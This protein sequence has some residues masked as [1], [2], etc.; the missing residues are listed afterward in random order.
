M[1]TQK[2]RMTTEQRSKDPDFAAK[3]RVLFR[4]IK[5]TH[6]LNNVQ[7]SEPPVSIARMTQN[8][9]TAIKPAAPTPTT[10]SLI[11]GNARYWAQNT[12][13]ILRDHYEDSIKN[14]MQI[15][16]QL[17]GEITQNFE[18]ASAWAR[19]QFGR[20]LKQA[21]LDN[22]WAKLRRELA[23]ARTDQV[24]SLHTIHTPSTADSGSR[25]GSIGRNPAVAQIP[26]EIT[27]LS[28][29]RDQAPRRTYSQVV[30]TQTNG[31]R[32][33]PT[34]A[35]QF[36]GGQSPTTA[37]GR[38]MPISAQVCDL[39]KK[40]RLVTTATMTTQRGGDWSPDIP[41]A[42]PLVREERFAGTIRPATPPSAWYAWTSPSHPTSS[43]SKGPREREMGLLP[44]P[45]PED[46]GPVLTGGRQMTI[47]AQVHHPARGS[48]RTTE[49]TAPAQ[50][51][52]GGW[53][54]VIPIIQLP[55]RE[56]RTTRASRPGTPSLT[57]DLQRGNT[58]T[59]PTSPA[60]TPE[61]VGETESE[62]L[63][64]L[65]GGEELVTDLPRAS[66]SMIAT[67]SHG[68]RSGGHTQSTPRL[69][70]DLIQ[71]QLQFDQRVATSSQDTT[72][73]PTRRPTRHIN[74]KKK[75]VEWSLRARNKWL[76]L[77]DSNLARFPPFQHQELQVDSFPGATFRHAEAILA[78][79]EVSQEV[80]KVILSFGLNNRAQKT[81]QTTIKQL[82]RAVRMAKLAFP[83]AQIFIPEINFSRT[84]PHREQDN[85][86]ELNR[87]ITKHQCAIPEL[88]R[89]HF[90]TEKDGLHWTHATAKTMLA[91]WL[92]HLN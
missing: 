9:A 45:T 75:M 31:R 23:V 62:P 4:L 39:P 38:N 87:Y 69:I 86:R 8:L 3:I 20:R 37:T 72:Q 67:P 46:P 84:L 89:K 65:T 68:Q 14:D 80:Q 47:S 85:L 66:G 13:I 30:S 26:D 81:D 51:G 15:L 12:A 74:T 5:A 60:A 56:H 29:P 10:L 28:V 71:A 57:R 27:S 50:P 61:P 76:V 70:A 32:T 59:P 35:P 6:H 88:S 54:P 2:E 41:V 40:P 49:I 21:T 58:P 82:Q 42:Q 7:A 63:I 44:S 1:R 17:G 33:P 52:G 25:T 79:T 73:I 77:G 48:P 91:H 11:E 34:Q 55:P 64:D 43:T 90:T 16:I 92:E 18:I 53:S 83:Q 19:R 22:V 36:S 24:G 78:K